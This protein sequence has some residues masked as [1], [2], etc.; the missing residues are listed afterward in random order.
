MNKHQKGFAPIIVALIILF[1]IGAVAIG[2]SYKLKTKPKEIKETALDYK[3]CTYTIEEKNITLKN[4]YS[5]EEIAPNSASKII[6]QYFGDEVSSDLNGDGLSD[7]AFI[8]TQDTGG[9][10]VFYYITVALG[11]NDGCKGTNAILLGD[12]IAPQNIEIQD[13]KIIV[14]YADRKINEAMTTQPSIGITKQFI[15]GGTTLKDITTEEMNKEQSC[16]LSG[17]NIETSLCCGSTS[18]FPNLCLIGA[19]GCSPTNSH[20]IKTCNC[21][22]NKCFNGKECV[23]M[24]P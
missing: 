20:Q 4:G 1:L 17:G 7:V 8:L 16:L 9:S 6:T 2:Y 19:C 5:E 15:L 11:N 21:G 22:D 23:T 3:N 12:R 10:G 14:N 18:D 13:G 24:V